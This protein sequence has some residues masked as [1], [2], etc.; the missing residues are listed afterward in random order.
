VQARKEWLGDVECKTTVQCGRFIT[1][2]DDNDDNN[3][4]V[5]GGGGGDDN[6]IACRILGLMIGPTN[7]LEIL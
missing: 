7:S 4:K 2:D 6:N 3:N 1:D 5:D